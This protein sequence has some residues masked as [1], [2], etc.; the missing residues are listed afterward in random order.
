[1]PVYQEGE[2]IFE[3]RVGGLDYA[4]YKGAPVN[5]TPPRATSSP[6][7]NTKESGSKASALED[8]VDNR[9]ARQLEPTTA[10]EAGFLPY[11]SKIVAIIKENWAWPG[12]KSSLRALARFSVEADGEITGIRISESSGDAA[13]DESI[14]GALRKSSPLPAPPKSHRKDFSQVEMNFQP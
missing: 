14:T 12:E 3:F 1:V 5:P 11:Q 10:P 6:R 8:A 4:R 13:F 2:P 9:T 7:I